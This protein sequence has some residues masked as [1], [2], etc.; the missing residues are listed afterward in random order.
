MRILLAEA[1][2]ELGGKTFNRLEAM[3]HAVDWA[4]DGLS[5]DELLRGNPYAAVILNVALPEMDGARVIRRMRDR[6]STAAVLAVSTRGTVEDRIV[7]LDLGADDC[8]AAPFDFR[9]LEARVRSLLRRCSGQR[10]ALLSCADLSFDRAAQLVRV[11][12][13][14]VSVTRREM[15]LLEVLLANQNR[16]TSKPALLEQMFDHA[17]EPHQNAIEVLIARLRPKLAGSGAGIR[18]YRGLGYR[19]EPGASA[20]VRTAG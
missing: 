2:A 13:A 3:G 1:S 19:M 15:S 5:A 12:D 14:P 9:E 8:L 10:G 20:Q 17:A 18:T 4:R 11:G 7:L 6:Q 16:V